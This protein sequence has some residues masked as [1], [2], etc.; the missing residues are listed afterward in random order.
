M[1]KAS[2]KKQMSKASKKKQMN[3][4]PKRVTTNAQSVLN[5][6]SELEPITEKLIEELVNQGW[7]RTRI[8]EAQAMGFTF[9]SRARNSFFTKPTGDYS[10]PDKTISDG[11][12]IAVSELRAVGII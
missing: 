9:Y 4:R 11:G 1:S 7:E 2:K 6:L 10:N 5:A 12:I 8:Q 3:K